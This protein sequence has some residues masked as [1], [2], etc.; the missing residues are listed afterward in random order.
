MFLSDGMS[1]LLDKV[2]ATAVEVA[3]SRNALCVTLTDGRELRVPLAWF[4]RLLRATPKQRSKW[5]FI[6]GGIGIH[7]P[8]L[9]EDI[10]I[11][12]LLQPENFMRLPD[13][14]VSAAP[15]TSKKPPR[16]RTRVNRE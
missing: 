6:G 14:Q 9:D 11:A 3:F 2:E 16:S 7:W 12:S 13:P 4:P 8:S 1:I 10:S 5:E 15:S